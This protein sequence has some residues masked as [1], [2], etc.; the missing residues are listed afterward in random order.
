[1]PRNSSGVYTLPAGNPVVDNTV[2]LVDWANPTMEDLG[3]EITNSLPRNGSAPMTGPLLLVR[4]AQSA[5]E[6]VPLNQFQAHSLDTNNPHNVTRA[7][8]SAAKSGENADIT[9]TTALTNITSPVLTINSNGV[10]I[11]PT[12]GSINGYFAVKPSVGGVSSGVYTFNTP[13]AVNNAYGA[14]STTQSE[15]VVS[16]NRTGTADFLPL[17]F[18]TSFAARLKINVNGSF[19]FGGAGVGTAGQFLISQGSNG[20][21]YWADSTVTLGDKGDITVSGVGGSMWTIDAGAV[22]LV[23][24]TG[25]AG[26]GANTN[27]TS[28]GP[29]T[30]VTAPQGDA[31]T[32]LATTEFVLENISGRA[33]LHEGQISGGS[34]QV[35]VAIPPLATSFEVILSQVTLNNA[36]IPALVAYNA[37]DIAHSSYQGATT[38]LTAA[39]VT[40][41]D[42]VSNIPLFAGAANASLSISGRI[43][44]TKAMQSSGHFRWVYDGSLGTDDA[45]RTENLGGS[46][47][48]SS[49]LSAISL[50]ASTMSGGY[51]TVV[52]NY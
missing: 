15:V 32:K 49:E 23:K 26:S 37:S 40:T 20:T 22:T 1:M 19:D 12:S 44:F 11:T 21:P 28:V 34:L 14:L 18:Y 33:V 24:T 30:G 9:K 36:V 41:V 52:A 35:K 42:N 25:I 50:K 17:S 27:I 13:D 51:M 45:P 16:S 39:A 38:N 2:I 43:T 4:N 8:I 5:M 3:N 31:T 29:I 6:A 7:Q 48:L 10:T 47:T 46:F